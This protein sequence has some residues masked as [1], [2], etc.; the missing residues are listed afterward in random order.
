MCA[1]VRDP[2]D[3]VV[4]DGEV[5]GAWDGGVVVCGEAEPVFAVPEEDGGVGAEFSGEGCGGGWAGAAVEGE[6]VGLGGG[7]LCGGAVLGGGLGLAGLAGLAG[8][9]DVEFVGLAGA[10]LED[11]DFAA[12]EGEARGGLAVARGELCG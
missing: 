4:V 6:V 10:C 9:D 2:E 8:V 7:E 5:C 12:D 3:V 1:S 11:G